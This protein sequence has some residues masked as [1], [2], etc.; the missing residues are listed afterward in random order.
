[1][2]LSLKHK[3]TIGMASKGQIINNP[4]TG[5]YIEFIETAKETG[6][7]YTKI[8]IL[9]KAGGF[10]PVLHFH[11][12]MDE[13]FELISGRLSYELNKE[14][15]TITAGDK[16]ILPKNIPHTHYNE[17]AED[18][19]MYQIFTPSLDIDTFLEN[20]FGLAG[21]GQLPNGAPEFLQAMVWL[22]RFRSKTYLAAIPASV[23]NILSF[24]LSPLAATFGYKAAY[25]RFSGY[26][27]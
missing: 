27:I 9:V 18:L 15:K 4:L 16:I 10:K 23:Q 14:K 13:G 24:I 26:D 22:R 11:N 12:K 5:E 17:Q 25:K 19:L 7:A 2:T 8:K 1:M 20:F 3:T 6:G 21:E